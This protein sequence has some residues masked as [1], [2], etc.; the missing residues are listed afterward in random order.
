MFTM[1][2]TA[3]LAVGVQGLGLIERAYQNACATPATACRCAR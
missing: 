2:N 3:R 1:M